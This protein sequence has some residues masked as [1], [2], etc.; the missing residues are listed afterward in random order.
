MIK[1]FKK[2][3]NFERAYIIFPYSA[4]LIVIIGLIFG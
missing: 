1:D 3:D 2:L 4:I